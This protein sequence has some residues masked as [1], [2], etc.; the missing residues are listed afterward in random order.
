MHACKSTYMH[1]LNNV[2]ESCCSDIFLRTWILVLIFP[3]ELSLKFSF[4]IQNQDYQI[5]ECFIKN[6]E[7][8]FK[9]YE[10]N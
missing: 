7:K 9:I 10:Q 6:N 3:S 2:E 8:K 5:N 1:A 4:F